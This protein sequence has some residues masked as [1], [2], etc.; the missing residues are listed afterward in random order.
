M[1]AIILSPR[2]LPRAEANKPSFGILR[3]C[4][5]DSLTMSRLA[6]P[7]SAHLHV[8]RWEPGDSSS[9]NI[10]GKARPPGAAMDV[11]SWT[12]NIHRAP[13]DS[14]VTATGGASAG[15]HGASLFL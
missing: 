13:R 8:G 3:S 12:T 4:H 2:H 9:A 14:R 5:V 6:A 7:T 10:P 1:S 15:A 11:L